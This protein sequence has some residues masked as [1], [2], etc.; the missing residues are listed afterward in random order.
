MREDF[1]LP[2]FIIDGDLFRADSAGQRHRVCHEGGHLALAYDA[3]DGVLHRHGEYNAVK[4]WYDE[5]RSVLA[6]QPATA[7]LAKA[8]VLLD[9]PFDEAWVREVNRCVSVTGAVYGLGDR[10]ASLGDGYA[11][12]YPANAGDSVLNP[13]PATSM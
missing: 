3:L 13:T 5:T 7:G 10:I 12:D 1:D 11:S 4:T 2:Y 6:R 8:L 9:H